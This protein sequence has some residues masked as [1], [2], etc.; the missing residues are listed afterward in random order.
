MD[1]AELIKLW[2]KTQFK[3]SK[4]PNL[5]IPRGQLLKLGQLFRRTTNTDELKRIAQLKDLDKIKQELDLELTKT[6]VHY[7]VTLLESKVI[8][9]ETDF[10]PAKI[11]LKQIQ[12]LYD[13]HYLKDKNIPNTLE[14]L[15]K[16]DVYV[17]KTDLKSVRQFLA[18]APITTD[19]LNFK[20]HTE[21]NEHH[22]TAIS[23][24]AFNTVI[25]LIKRR[26]IKIS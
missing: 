1:I 8:Q 25:K 16:Q 17:T 4:T 9:F 24:T 15:K 3:P 18:K 19:I 14:L 7:L 21:Y 2:L 6:N 11:P 20:T 22:Q 23:K 10:T 5:P 13:N 26:I 12:Y